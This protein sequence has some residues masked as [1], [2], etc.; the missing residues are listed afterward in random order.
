MSRASREPRRRR[1]RRPGMLGIVGDV[2]GEPELR[3]GAIARRSSAEVLRAREPPPVVPRLR[4]GIGI[5]QE[6]PPERARPAA[7][8]SGPARRPACS[9][10]LPT[11]AASIRPSAIATPLTNGSQPISPTSGCACACATRCS[12]PPKPISSQTGR[13]SPNRAAPAAPA[14]GSPQAPPPAPAAAAAAPRAAA[15][16]SPAASCRAAGRRGCAAARGRGPPSRRRM[17]RAGRLALRPPWRSASPRSVRSQEKPPSL[18]GGP[19]EVAVG[20]GPLV[21]RPVQP[22]VRADAPR[23]QVHDL[24]H[25]LL[26]RR[27]RHLAGAEGVGVDRQRPRHADRIGELQHAA[28]RQPRR[29]HVLREVARRIGRR[30]VDLGRIL[31]REGPAAVRRRA[32]VGVDDD[33]AP[34]Q[35]GVAVRPADARTCR[36]G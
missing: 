24:R 31:A 7:A 9:R 4:P 36:S 8:R 30:A 20:R 1:H 22:E 35:P 19:A 23:R 34:G 21:D 15:A 11:P 5:E 27:L 12:P 6:H 33:L 32:A 17:H 13:P 3:P 26:D 14:P 29:H 2:G 16:A 25:R 18:S 28:L 10:T